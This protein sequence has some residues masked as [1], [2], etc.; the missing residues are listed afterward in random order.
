[1]PD[2][3]LFPLQDHVGEAL[4]DDAGRTSDLTPQRQVMAQKNPSSP[5]RT[6]L[7]TLRALLLDSTAPFAD[8]YE[9]YS[10]EEAAHIAK[11]G[12]EAIAGDGEPGVEWGAICNRFRNAVAAAQPPA[13]LRDAL[14]VIRYA[15][16]D[17]DEDVAPITL[18]TADK[19]RLLQGAYST[20]AAVMEARSAFLI[21]QA[22]R[23]VLLVAQGATVAPDAE[24]L[25]SAAR[26]QQIYDEMNDTTVEDDVPDEVVTEYNRLINTIAA[27]PAHTAEGVAAKLRFFT[28]EVEGC[29]YSYISHGRTE[30][31]LPQF[32]RTALEGAQRLTCGAVV[33]ADPDAELL[34]AFRTFSDAY[35][36]IDD[37]GNEKDPRA[38]VAYQAMYGAWDKIEAT[39]PQT[40]AGLAAYL[41]VVI[42]NTEESREIDDALIY[43]KPLDSGYQFACSGGEML[44]KLIQHLEGGAIVSAD[45]DAELLEMG[46]QIQNLRDRINALTEA[47]DPDFNHPLWDEKGK[48]EGRIVAST[49]RTA[50]GIAVI[51]RVLYDHSGGKPE[52]CGP[53]ENSDW[54]VKALWTAIQACE[55]LG[56]TRSARKSTPDSGQQP[57][58]FADAISAFQGEA[59]KAL[60]LPTA[61]T[62]NML[63]AG[64]AAAGIDIEQARA[65]YAAMAEAY[66]KEA[67]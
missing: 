13:T 32:I 48:V 10:A 16:D 63:E 7:D 37:I 66:K 2:T 51:L 44:W 26:A 20:V 54:M 24:L 43:G 12:L 11:H 30:G 40:A 3:F 55:R 35:R 28:Y 15:R 58:G 45:L 39:M 29:V 1:M 38:E 65:I 67:A 57:D 21:K 64:A 4:H 9:R 46:R 25:S 8:A 6:P 60:S 62:V 52:A 33:F 34:S 56:A 23:S 5:D 17:E 59:E 14:A 49:P 31:L 42:H 36:Q 47:E 22:N 27:L 50:A 18:D 53:T 19:L 61:P 41:K